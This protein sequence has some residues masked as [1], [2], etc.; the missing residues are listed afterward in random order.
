MK[1]Q[2]LMRDTSPAIAKKI[3][4]LMQ[5]KNP[6]ERLEMGCSM[7]QTSKYLIIRSILNEEPNISSTKLRLE[8]FMRFYG[9][10]FDSATRENILKYLSTKSQQN[11]S[12]AF[13]KRK[14]V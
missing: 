3:A 7:Y 6:E 10:D 5:L 1:G 14:L 11:C 2:C 4:E 9:D 13:G 12:T 8:F